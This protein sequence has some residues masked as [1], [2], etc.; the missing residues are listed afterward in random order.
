MS[1]IFGCPKRSIKQLFEYENPEF[2]SI[3]L[4]CPSKKYLWGELSIFLNEETY[5]K[6]SVAKRTII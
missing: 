2:M 5:F 3:N 1:K 6:D 4:F